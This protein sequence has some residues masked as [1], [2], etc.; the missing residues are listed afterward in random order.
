M[1]NSFKLLITLLLLILFP[2]SNFAQT[3]KVDY[4]QP[5][6]YEIGGISV[7]GIKYLDQNALIQLSGLN[8]GEEVFIPGEEITKAI[9]KLWKQGLFS[10]IKIQAVKVEG[11]KIFLNIYLQERS[12]LSKVVFEGIKKSHKKDL[13]EKINLTA[14]GQI[15]DNMISTARKIIHDFYDEKGYHHVDI[16]MVQKSDPALSNAIILHI[17]ISKNKRVKILNI[18][19]VGN[20]VL[21]N[22]KIKRSMKNTK[23]KRWYS[24]FKSS[25]YLE[26]SFEE[27]KLSIL[28]KY[29]ELG[30]RDAR[31]VKDSIYKIDD[32]L[33]GLDLVIEEG[34]KFY[35]RNITWVG[36]TKYSTKQ[37]SRALGIKKGDIFDQNI[38]DKRLTIDDNAVANIYLDDGYLFFNVSP[39]ETAIVNDS[40]DLEMRV[41]EGKQAR[42]N[43]VRIIGN[44]KTNEHV[45]RREIR[46]LP[47]ELFSKSA[48]MR[49][50]RELSQL[51]HFDPEKMG[52][53]PIPNQADGTVDLEYTV[54]ERANDQIEISG[55]WGAGQIVG[56]IGLKFT[57][58]SIG[59][60]FKKEAWQP[61]PTGD[62]Q[63][64]SLRVQ[65]NGAY[66]QSYSLSFTEPWLGGRKPNSFSFSVYHTIQKQTYYTGTQPV[67]KILGASIGLGTRLKLPDDFFFIRNQISLQRYNL[68]NWSG[69]IFP[70]GVSHD[71]SYQVTFGR[72][73]V[74]SPL[75][76]RGGSSFSLALKL[77]PPF[78]LMNSKDYINASDEEKYKWTEYHKWTFKAEWYVRLLGDLVLSNKMQA[79]FLGYYNDDIGMSPFGGYNVGG[80]GMSGYNFYGR[81]TIGLRGYE[82]NS[83]TPEN[84]AALYNKLT[85]EL[86]YPISLN[87]SAIIYG[88]AFL[89][90]G[91][92]WSS[93]DEYNPFEL[94]RTAGVGLRLFLPMIG[95]MGIDWGYGFDEIPNNPGK[96]GGQWHFVLGQ[97][98]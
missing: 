25:K 68:T 52:V 67:F 65:S 85:M 95:L 15:T 17:K 83:L 96:N 80:D 43:E 66:Y 5:Q 74:D 71:L 89:E 45:V 73:S 40:I 75:Y 76:P 42:I 61:L 35:F 16:E 77:T 32:K 20:E 86:R 33:L 2:L 72:N 41:Y 57:N 22:K 19:I 12:R 49:T 91:N 51:G 21:S 47:G 39:N 92:A 87:P 31:I 23:R 11:S 54:E 63:T 46:T 64:L 69:F 79:G 26:T 62:G 27:D 94:R 3:I 9:E 82:N 93:F 30:Y 34:H 4:A 29:N 98:F 78:S 70:D 90:A 53:N 6:K 8:V 1:T 50:I 97:Q 60:T 36:N 18:N 28:K 10:D 7:S 56:T 24:L 59:N 81:E 38:L 84:G 37:L 55:G 58:F 88:M 44:T 13:K 14:G 48:I